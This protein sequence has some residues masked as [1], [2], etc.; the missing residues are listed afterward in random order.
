MNFSGMG[1]ADYATPLVFRRMR[2]AYGAIVWKNP[3][4][5]CTGDR[6]FIRVPGLN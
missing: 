4:S 1:H 6:R 3:A 5:K 2:R